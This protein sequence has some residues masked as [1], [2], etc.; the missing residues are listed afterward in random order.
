MLFSS[1]KTS[2]AAELGDA[3]MAVRASHVASE[4]RRA[5]G[6]AAAKEAFSCPRSLPAADLAAA[7]T[8]LKRAGAAD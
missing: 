8:A 3:A 5:L 4:L 7:R 6:E 1:V 2:P